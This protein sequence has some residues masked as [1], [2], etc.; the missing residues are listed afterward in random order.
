MNRSRF[1]PAFLGVGVAFLAI[2]IATNRVF[3][4]IG[5]AFLV[6]GFL[7]LSRTRER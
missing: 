4:A 3:L 7:G 6:L 2:G 1:N 5:V